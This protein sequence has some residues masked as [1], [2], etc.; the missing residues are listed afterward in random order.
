MK[1]T[2]AP[3]KPAA[4]AKGKI[5]MSMQK[6]EEIRMMQRNEGHFDCF[7]RAEAGYCDQ[8]GC[9]HYMEC[10]TASQMLYT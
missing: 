10:M 8:S 7:G 1:K 5:G 4:R 9:S 6:V 2:T 3:K